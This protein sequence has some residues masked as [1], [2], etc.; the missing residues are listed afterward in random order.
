MICLHLRAQDT[1]IFY[2]TL[3]LVSNIA[4]TNLQ[5]AKKMSK[6][7]LLSVVGKYVTPDQDD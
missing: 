7:D 2:H 4:S 5:I 6:C 3:W 1:R